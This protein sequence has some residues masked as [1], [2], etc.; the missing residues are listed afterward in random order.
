M[1]KVKRRGTLSMPVLILLLT[2]LSAC[3]T[4]P[5]E[6]YQEVSATDLPET[7]LVTV[8]MGDATW[9]KFNDLH[10]DGAKY[11]AV[12]LNPGTY[13]IEYSTTFG[14]SFM[15]DPRMLVSQAVNMTI[16]LEAGRTYRLRADRTYGRGYAM[17]FWIE[18]TQGNVVNEIK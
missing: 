7:S 16:D 18:D 3:A 5:K 15:V 8:E 10:I 11:S 4:A 17:Y 12:K 13:R 6:V 1:N 14:V 9:A 2:F